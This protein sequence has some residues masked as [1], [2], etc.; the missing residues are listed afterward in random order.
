MSLFKKI[1]SN[2][3]EINLD[4]EL[5]D[6]ILNI[7]KDEV[8]TKNQELIRKF[9]DNKKIKDDKSLKAKIKSDIDNNVTSNIFSGAS[10]FKFENLPMLNWEVS[11]TNGFNFGCYGEDYFEGFNCEYFHKVER[12]QLFLTD[13]KDLDGRKPTD[14]ADA[15]F[16]ELEGANYLTKNYFQELYGK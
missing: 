13:K 11:Y 3:R 12:F 15:L 16:W 8:L 1:F 4:K 5:K 2:T 10:R 7:Y 9:A 6:S 14:M